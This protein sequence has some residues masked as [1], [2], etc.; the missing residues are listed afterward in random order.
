MNDTWAAVLAISVAV[1]AFVQLAVLI[2]LAIAARRVTTMIEKTQV[3][4][5]GLAADLKVRVASVTESVNAVTARLNAVAEDVKGV[6]ARVQQV[7]GTLSDGVQRMEQT[8]RSA[9]QKVADTVQQVPGP[10]KKGVPV[11]LAI[12]AALRTV[13][14]VRQKM[15][16]D[17][18]R[19]A[20]SDD[21][22]YASMHG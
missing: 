4:V 15:R 12:L 13:Q 1:M 17:R 7:A 21:D 19:S 18:A 8:V 16:A 10:V 14:Q 20:F 9:G 11:G 3:Q 5:E 2:G 22:M 6:T